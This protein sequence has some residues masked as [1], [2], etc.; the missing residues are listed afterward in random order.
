MRILILGGTVFLSK[1]TAVEA[2]ARGHQVTCAARG[3][4]GSTPEGARFVR[5]ERDTDDGVAA[6]ADESYDA[7]VDVARLPSQVRRATSALAGKAKHWTFVSTI[8]VYSDDRTTG[9]TTDA[10]V[11]D[12]L[13]ADVVGEAEADVANYGPAKVACERIVL[14]ALGDRAF[15]VRA[16]L[17]VGPGDR[18][19]R[20]TYWPVRMARGGEVLAPGAPSDPVQSID[21]RDLASWIVR[22]AESGVTGTYDGTA[23][24]TTR[25]E[26]LARTAA[27]VA[28]DASA[29]ELTWVAQDFLLANGV[30]PWSGPRSL[31][32]WLPMPDDAGGMSRDV[33]AASDAGLVV[34]DIAETAADT[35][36]A[37]REAGSEGR[38]RCGLDAADEAELL[39][40]WHAR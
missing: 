12:P 29:T 38:L 19:D 17:I 21:V 24:A 31:P 26:L 23:P 7:V 3:Q 18:S 34:R 2:L 8:S 4:S 37:A 40:L 22:S 1:A 20:G 39:R 25:A 33:T 16:G 14:D 35:L 13:P 10:P 36:A 15:V 28:A 30:Q 27:G 6:L 11:F 32:L 9:Q 5:V